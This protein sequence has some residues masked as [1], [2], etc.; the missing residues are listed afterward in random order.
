MAPAKN[1]PARWQE[2][3]PIDRLVEAERN[4]KAHDDEGLDASLERFGYIEPIVMDER[5]GRLVSGHGRLRRLAARRERGEDPPEG[6]ERRARNRWW[7]PVNRGWRSADDDEAKAAVIALNR[8]GERGGWL[9]DPLA[10]MLAELNSGPG[11]G[12]T[13]YS[14]ADLDSLLADLALEPPAPAPAQL[15]R[16]PAD[17]DEVAPLPEAP[18]SRRGDLW[19]MGEH[20]LLVGD[21]SQAKDVERLMDGQAAACLWSDPPYGVDYVGKT[22]RALR[23]ENDT[24]AN[25]RPFLAHTWAAV[26]PAL[27]PGAPFYLASPPGRQGTAIRLSLED[28]GW[29]LHECLVWVKDAFVLGHSDYHFRHEDVLYGWV[30]G[31]GR[32]GRGNHAGSRWRGGN[33]A[34]TVF[35]VPR[36]RRSA[37]HPTIKPVA[38]VRPHIANSTEH[39]DAVLDCF[40]GSGVT[41][42]AAHRLGR[43]AFLLEIDPLYA[44]VILRRWISLTGEDPHTVE[45]EGWMSRQK[46]ACTSA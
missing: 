8:I 27:E 43:R 12:G 20:R 14:P 7:A 18:A 33:A 41:L 1:R 30:P 15:T 19:V 46:A 42:V 38:L 35:E 32:S 36:P 21:A 45:G 39:G 37:D 28:V 5:T 31:P 17:D 16:A 34:D 22:K 9:R 10:E 6:V 4:P 26:A 2:Y 24:P 11:L 25:L 13:G 23:I 29:M 40:A 3:M 44:D